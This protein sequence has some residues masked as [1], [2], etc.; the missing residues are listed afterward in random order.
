MLNLGT[1]IFWQLLEKQVAYQT[2]LHI[3][4]LITSYLCVVLVDR[5]L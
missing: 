4:N 1:Q 3:V 2:L 5:I